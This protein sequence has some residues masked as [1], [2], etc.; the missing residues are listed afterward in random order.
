MSQEQKSLRDEFA[1]TALEAV[2]RKVQ[3]VSKDED[4]N[5][6]FNLGVQRKELTAAEIGREVMRIANSMVSERDSA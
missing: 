1:H 4:D 5:V 6:V 2:L 3:M